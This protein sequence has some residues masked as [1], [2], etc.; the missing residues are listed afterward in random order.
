MMAHGLVLRL[1]RELLGDVEFLD[2]RA[3]RPRQLKFPKFFI[4]VDFS[5]I[6]KIF[7]LP[8]FGRRRSTGGGGGDS[9]DDFQNCLP[10]TALLPASTLDF[11]VRGG[12]AENIS[13]ISS[14][15]VKSSKYRRLHR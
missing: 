5:A 10:L 15:S 12:F 1:V 13:T 9:G 6:S 8:R 3:E 2:T 11:S 14:T 7:R 4:I